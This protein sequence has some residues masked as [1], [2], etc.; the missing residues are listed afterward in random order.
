[1]TGGEVKLFLTDRCCFLNYE[2]PI[3]VLNSFIVCPSSQ[4]RG[5]VNQKE[6]HDCLHARFATNYLMS[7]NLLFVITKGTQ[8]LI[9]ILRKCVKKQWSIDPTLDS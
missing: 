7:D 1:M 3:I 5:E 9:G 2:E 6:T 8:L 4:L